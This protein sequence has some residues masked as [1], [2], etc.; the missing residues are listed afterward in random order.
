M[1][2]DRCQMSMEVTDSNG[3]TDPMYAR[4]EKWKCPDCGETAVET[5]EG[6]L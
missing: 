3:E 4:V 1:Y 6:L 2:C 5:L